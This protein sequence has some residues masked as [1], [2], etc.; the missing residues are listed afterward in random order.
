LFTVITGAA[1]GKKEKAARLIE[2]GAEM[3]AL[4][5]GTTAVIQA[6]SWGGQFDL[7]LM[8][9]NAGADFRQ[10]E[11]NEIQRLIHVVVRQERRLGEYSPERKAKF[12]ELVKWLEDH[13]ESYE[14]AKA[15]LKRWD[16][17]SRTRGEFREKMDAEIAKR[18]AREQRAA[19]AQPK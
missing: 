3:S 14:E 18:K 9:L 15:D 4:A 13:G 2:L 7:A 6:V 5:V 17:W 11:E 16:S 19:D 1:S 8:M 10:Y 12:H